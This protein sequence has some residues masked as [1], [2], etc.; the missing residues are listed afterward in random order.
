MGRGDNPAGA[1]LSTHP[2]QHAVRE[3]GGVVH[4]GEGGRAGAHDF[5]AHVEHPCA[6]QG[7]KGHSEEEAPVPEHANV[8]KGQR[9]APDGTDFQREVQRS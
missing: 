8:L 1:R 4:L 3:G 9:Q 6:P 7:Q 2:D 5:P